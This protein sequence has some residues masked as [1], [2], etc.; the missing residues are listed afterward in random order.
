MVQPKV[1]P[2]NGSSKAI[3]QTI[4]GPLGSLKAI[5]FSELHLLNIY[6]NKR[7]SLKLSFSYRVVDLKGAILKH[8][9]YM[10]R[11]VGYHPFPPRGVL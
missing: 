6:Q 8:E 7:M 5:R 11:G 3:T 1:Q 2:C 9:T 4:T 10:K